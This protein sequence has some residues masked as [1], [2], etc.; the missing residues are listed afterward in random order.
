MRPRG[1]HLRCLGWS[2]GAQKGPT[3]RHT[4]STL[5][6]T[7]LCLWPRAALTND[8]K[9]GL[10]QQ[11]GFLTVLKTEART[12]AAA[13]DSFRRRCGVPAPGPGA[14]GTLTFAGLWPHRSHLSYLHV[15][16]PF[17]QAVSVSPPPTRARRWFQVP[18]IWVLSSGAGVQPRWIQGDSKVGT[19][20]ASLHI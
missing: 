7:R 20:S 1:R 5:P 15:A 4:S 11:T 18:L 8:H 14:L 3:D 13:A 10:K 12:A 16:S 6:G 2:L 19:E 9:W 17:V